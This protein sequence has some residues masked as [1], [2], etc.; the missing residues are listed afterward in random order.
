[1]LAEAKGPAPAVGGRR[2]M[3]ESNESTIR[4]LSKFLSA[5]VK[6]KKYELKINDAKTTPATQ[7]SSTS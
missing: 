3:S 7:P 2:S 5:I 1:M 4:T 6:K